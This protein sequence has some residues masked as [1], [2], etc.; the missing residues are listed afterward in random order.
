MRDAV[1][2]LDCIHMPLEQT[3]YIL[4]V[5]IW[6]DFQYYDCDT[7]CR[8]F[9]LRSRLEETPDLALKSRVNP[10]IF[11]MLPSYSCDKESLVASLDSIEKFDFYPNPLDG[12]LFYHR[13]VHYLPGSTP[14]VGW[15]KGYMV[16]ELIGI[17]VC[18][19]LM[20]QR[21]NSYANMKNYIKEYDDEQS[22]KERD[23]KSKAKAKDD[24]GEEDLSDEYKESEMNE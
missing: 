7:D 24:Q 12:L 18:Q 4:D 17:S 16:P 22:A 2:F 19:D 20:A 9:M 15:L 5:M 23:R 21:P 1:T 13:Q 10:F 14:L 11:K 6:K 3:F 8:R